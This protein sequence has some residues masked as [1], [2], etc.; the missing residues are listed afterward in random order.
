MAKAKPKA[1]DK[2]PAKMGRPEEYT[3]ELGKEIC[4]L[5][6]VDT[7]SLTKLCEAH[8][9]WPNWRTVYRWRLI[10]DDFCHLYTEAR[11]SQ[12]DIRIDDCE[13]I[14][15]DCDENNAGSVN[16]ARLICDTRKWAASKVLPKVYG[17][18]AK[19]EKPDNPHESRIDMIGEE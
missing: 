14:A 10:Y 13:N 12:A 9:H 8:A 6:A 11:K 3:P 7:R 18:A 17:D 15:M 1:A 4:N 19:K 5:L 16:K 2:I